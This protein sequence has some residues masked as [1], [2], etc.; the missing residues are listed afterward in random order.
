MNKEEFLNGVK[1]VKCEVYSRIV[2]Y[3]KPVQNWHDSKKQEFKERKYLK[4]EN[5]E[6][7]A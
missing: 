5:Q 4:V 2:G 6:K 7:S 1:R 3:L